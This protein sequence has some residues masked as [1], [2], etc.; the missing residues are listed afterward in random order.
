MCE[1]SGLLSPFPIPQR[2]I[3]GSV[4]ALVCVE[5]EVCVCVCLC[6]CV[7]E[8]GTIDIVPL[9]PEVQSIHR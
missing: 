6:V 9:T 8:R 7:R 5:V 4:S 2:A 3:R 1:Q